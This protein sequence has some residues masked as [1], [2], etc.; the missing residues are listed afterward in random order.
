MSKQVLTILTFLV[1]IGWIAASSYFYICKVQNNCIEKTI[2]S[3]EAPEI[4][5]PVS[6]DTVEIEV[7]N[8]KPAISLVDGDNLILENKENFH[9]ALG[10]SE[11]LNSDSMKG[12]LA[13][14]KSY[15]SE[16]E[17]KQ[18]IIT[19]LYSKED[20]EDEQLGMDRASSVAK[21]IAKDLG[22]KKTKLLAEAQNIESLE[23]DNLSKK[24]INSISYTIVEAQKEVKI[25]ESNTNKVSYS[26]VKGKRLIYYGNGIFDPEVATLE[27]ESYLEDL[28]SYFDQN[29]KGLVQLTGHSDSDQGLDESIA[30]SYKR[31]DQLKRFL[32]K[33]YDI[34]PRNIRTSGKGDEERVDFSGT[35]IAKAKNR[36]VE[37][38]LIK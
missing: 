2:A 25:E 19:G 9:F 15:L 5:Q 37:F 29:P 16:N 13:P 21:F 36:R 30:I 6:N 27:L 28:K 22:I 35:E 11:I 32:T 38:R 34:N 3:K 7:K 23:K 26:K 17:N 20:Q 14:L 1:L 18:V 31:A 33:E 12:K 10:Q 4:V 8:I 24:A